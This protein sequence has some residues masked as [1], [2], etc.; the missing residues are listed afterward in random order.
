MAIWMC[1]CGCGTHHTAGIRERG[2]SLPWLLFSTIDILRGAGRWTVKRQGYKKVSVTVQ[3]WGKCSAKPFPTS[4][5]PISS[6]PF[7]YCA[8]T[9]PLYPLASLT[10]FWP[11]PSLFISCFLH[12][13]RP[14]PPVLLA[15]F[16]W[17][18]IFVASAPLCHSHPFCFVLSILA[19]FFLP[20]P[21]SFR[22]LI[23]TFL[24]PSAPFVS[25]SLIPCSC[26]LSPISCPAP[27]SPPSTSAQP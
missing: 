15:S 25:Y 10:P 26:W 19:I 17:C 2:P 21:S 27:V 20:W 16:F 8:F 1:P 24:F 7:I 6:P 12:W 22:S 3:K 14:S 23:I 9:P 13:E 4:F 5:C 18:F 11:L